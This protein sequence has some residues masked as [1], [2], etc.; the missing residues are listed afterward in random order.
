MNFKYRL[1]QILNKILSESEFDYQNDWE[2]FRQERENLRR[3]AAADQL[4]AADDEAAGKLQQKINRVGG[5]HNWMKTDADWQPPE[6]LILIDDIETGH[7]L[8]LPSIQ[9]K[10]KELYLFIPWALVE[11]TNPTVYKEGNTGKI[12]PFC[13]FEEDRWPSK[14]DFEWEYSRPRSESG[15]P[16]K[17]DRDPEYYFLH[18]VAWN[19]R[20]NLNDKAAMRLFESD[21]NHYHMLRGDDKAVVDSIVQDKADDWFRENQ[22]TEDYEDFHGP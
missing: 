16:D 12:F 17:H 19:K 20:N 18:D 11:V 14:P 7:G 4:K 3:Q 1:R 5:L 8:L 6:K 10:G 9:K 13:Q 22:E 15:V 21:K 2:K